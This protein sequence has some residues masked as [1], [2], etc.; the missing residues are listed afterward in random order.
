MKKL[1]FM[2]SAVLLLSA[3]NQPVQAT[4]WEAV[5]KAAKIIAEVGLKAYNAI[6]N[7]SYALTVVASDGSVAHS[8]C[9]S[10]E[11]ALWYALKMLEQ[12]A[13]EVTIVSDYPTVNGSCRGRTYTPSDI[14]EKKKK[15]R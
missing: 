5:G 12:G 8:K 10:C 14:N 3:A 1:L 11:D 4:D 2:M 13:K 9:E 6:P 15:L 7:A